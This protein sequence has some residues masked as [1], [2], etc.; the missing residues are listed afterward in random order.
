MD[1]ALDEMIGHMDDAWTSVLAMEQFLIN[2]G[3]CGLVIPWE[4]EVS[5]SRIDPV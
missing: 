5:P 3:W 2:I 4:L 1:L